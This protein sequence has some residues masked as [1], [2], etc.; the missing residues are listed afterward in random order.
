MANTFS[1][2]VLVLKKTKLGES[3]L[4]LTMLS[5]EGSLLKAVGKGARRPGSQIGSRLELFN[6]V[7]V[8][9]AKGKGLDIAKEA[10]L[11]ERFDT[12]QIDPFRAAAASCV[13]E[14]VL[15]IA[16]P[17]LAVSKLYDMTRAC[18]NEI[19]IAS[20]DQLPILVAA[21][22]LKVSSITGMRPYFSI[23]AICQTPIPVFE[24]DQNILSSSI[25][26]SAIDGG[27]LCDECSSGV[28]TENLSANVAAWAN[29]SLMS[30]F[31]DISE[32]G[33]SGFIAWDVLYLAHT[34]VQTH[35]G[36]KIKS[37]TAFK[38]LSIS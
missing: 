19:N 8:L 9:F 36:S 23:C 33:V 20:A 22:F 14:I 4:I 7:H 34:W 5:A 6:A 2:D 38:D 10:R 13:S 17:E 29:F 24:S 37:L 26:Y 12:L 31:A 18:L 15:K 11:I 1:D 3:D 16:Q 21:F 30:T 27:A 32:K 35:L 28:A 25:K